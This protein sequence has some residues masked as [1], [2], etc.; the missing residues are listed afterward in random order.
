[1][2][3]FDVA[4][5]PE[6]QLVR[7]IAP[8]AELFF[9]HTIKSPENIR[10]AYFEYGVRN[11]SLDHEDE[12]TKIIES[13]EGA[14]D[15]NLFVRVALPKNENASIDFSAK[16]GAHPETAPALLLMAR[17]YAQRLGICFHVGT[18][19]RD[20][21]SYGN[22]VNRIKSVIRESGVHI[23]MLDIGGGFPVPYEG[24]DVPSVE[25]CLS[26]INTA[27]RHAELDHLIL[28]AEPGRC[29]VA[30]G[31]SLVVRV[32]LRKDDCLYIN[33]GTY[34]GLFDAGPLLKTPF[35]VRAVR[36]AQA[37]EAPALSGN[38]QAFRLAGPTCDGL[39]MMDGPFYLP[40]NIKT[41]DWIEIQNTGAYSQS[42]RTNFN[43]FGHHDTVFVR[44][45]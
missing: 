37:T 36:A 2:R 41:G 11:F 22:A 5:M 3:A 30:Q 8:D 25:S 34:G 21:A 45:N 19:T 15:L 33:D 31:G 24:E 29:L 17:R 10:D 39:D 14:T 27:L 16:F 1:M 18:Q 35:P 7:D 4:S 6:I 13:T 44:S 9:M 43:G 12:L 40:E 23:D 32:E 38:L 42:L 26:V 20:A 28:F